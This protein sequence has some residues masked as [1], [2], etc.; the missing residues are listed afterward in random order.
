MALV[1]GGEKRFSPA[2]R[3][4]YFDAAGYGFTGKSDALG[5]EHR[6]V[7]IG[8]AVRLM[9][10]LGHG[11]TQPQRFSWRKALMIIKTP[12]RDLHGRSLAGPLPA[13]RYE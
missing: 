3:Q 4:N 5:V 13:V 6:E 10:H 8:F 12:R 1:T 11:A 9:T 7:V 2:E